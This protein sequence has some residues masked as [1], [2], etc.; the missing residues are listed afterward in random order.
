MQ[1]LASLREN[2]LPGYVSR[3]GN[4][5]SKFNKFEYTFKQSTKVNRFLPSIVYKLDQ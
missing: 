3:D 2:Y 1:K 4:K 5:I